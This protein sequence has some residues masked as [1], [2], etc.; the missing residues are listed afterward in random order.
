MS[1]VMLAKFQKIQ[2]FS[3]CQILAMRIEYNASAQ[4]PW[5]FLIN[6]DGSDAELCHIIDDASE[7]KNLIEQHSEVAQD[8]KKALLAWSPVF[9]QTQEI[10]SYPKLRI[11]QKSER[12]R[13]SRGG[14]GCSA[15]L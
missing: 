10:P 1:R 11:L 15:P 4:G 14:S 2:P 13:M 7:S 6:Y 9:P 5:K 3:Y 12:G 8:L